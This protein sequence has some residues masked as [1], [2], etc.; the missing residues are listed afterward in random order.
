MAT[1]VLGD[2][3]ASPTK[4]AQPVLPTVLT[5]DNILSSPRQR[6]QVQRHNIAEFTTTKSRAHH[7]GEPAATTPATPQLAAPIAS[8]SSAPVAASG[9]RRPAGRR[10]GS[11]KKF[12]EPPRDTSSRV[13]YPLKL[14]QLTVHAIGVVDV[15]AA[16]HTSNQV[17]RSRFLLCR[18]MWSVWCSCFHLATRRRE[19]FLVS[20]RRICDVET[21]NNRIRVRLC[22]ETSLARRHGDAQRTRTVHERN[23]RRRRRDACVRDHAARRPRPARAQRVGVWRRQGRAHSRQSGARSRLA[24]RHLG[25]ELLR[26]HASDGDAADARSRPRRAMSRVRAWPALWYGT[27]QARHSR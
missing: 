26:S 23:R 19:S 15:R 4:C 2:A 25:T 12:V 21:S 18:V 22:R 14:G 16:F 24:E 3:V 13:I 17:R 20:S 10:V 7:R 6:H 5:T 11:S 1:T 27:Q 8:V 9:T